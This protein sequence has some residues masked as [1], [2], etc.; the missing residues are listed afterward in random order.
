MSQPET[1]GPDQA[2]ERL[3]ET[4]DRLL[5]E[6]GPKSPALSPDEGRAT[7]RSPRCSSRRAPTS[8]RRGRRSSRPSPRACARQ[9]V[10]PANG[11][12]GARRW[13][14]AREPWRRARPGSP[15]AG[16]PIPGAVTSTSAA[17]NP[18]AR[19]ARELTLVN[20]EW[21][22]V[23]RCEEVPPGTAVPFTAGA[24]M[25]H[26]V[27]Q[28]RIIR[29]AVGHLHAHGLR[30]AVGGRRQSLR[31]PLPQ[32][33]VR[34]RRGHHPDAGLPWTPPPLTAPAGES[35]GRPGSGCSAPAEAPPLLRG[36]RHESG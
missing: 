9:L 22:R 24:I 5:A 33:L 16:S 11:S 36:H 26:L 29:C 21:S 20:G 18:P 6:R 15:S 2:A 10:Q 14:P 12:R 32:R 25:G 4:I 28:R 23:A 27:N 7:G 13:P 30:P 35:R 17:A 19:P 8:P 34:R 31:L 3:D 1:E